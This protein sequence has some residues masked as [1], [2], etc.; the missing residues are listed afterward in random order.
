MLIN[1]TIR[2]FRFDVRM[3]T[4]MIF[5]CRPLRLPGICPQ[6]ILPATTFGRV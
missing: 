2:L 5:P 4:E 6:F 1:L 3:I